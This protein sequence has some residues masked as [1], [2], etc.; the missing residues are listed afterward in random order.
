MLLVELL[1]SLTMRGEAGPVPL[2]AR[3]KRPLSLIAILAVGGRHGLSRQRVEAYLWPEST[4]ARAR[5]ALDQ[6]VYT[7][8]HAVGSDAIV[9]TGHELRLNSACARVDAS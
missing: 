3:Q 8:R 4:A 2:A 1:G 5:H 9:S 6:A 7:I